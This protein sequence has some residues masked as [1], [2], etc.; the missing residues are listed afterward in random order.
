MVAKLAGKKLDELKKNLPLNQ[1]LSTPLIQH[2]KQN[3][4]AVER[5]V[6]DVSETIMKKANVTVQV[7]ALSVID[8]VYSIIFRDLVM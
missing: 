6:D 7:L 5:F 1:I 2:L 8:V 4:T 3:K